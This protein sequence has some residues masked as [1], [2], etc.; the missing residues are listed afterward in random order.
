MMSTPTVGFPADFL[1]YDPTR[2][3]V[4]VTSTTNCYNPN[5][6]VSPALSPA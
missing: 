5:A 6:G 1:R 2:V 4:D 3:P